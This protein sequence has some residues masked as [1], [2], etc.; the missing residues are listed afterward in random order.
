MAKGPMKPGEATIFIRQ[1]CGPDLKLHWTG[2]ARDR[3][4][5][6]DLI[7][8]DALHVLKHGF[9]HDEA[10]EATRR[11]TWKYCIECVTPNS[12]GR[13]IRLVVIPF[14]TCDIKIVTVMWADERD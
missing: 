13:T 7:M 11:G 10:E 6:R 9:V 5:E 3:L 12:R 2:H 1:K 14:T 8:G 4:V